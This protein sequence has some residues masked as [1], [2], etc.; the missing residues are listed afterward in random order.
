M[1]KVETA[2]E[3]EITNGDAMTYNLGKNLAIATRSLK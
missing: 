3:K 2:K 1:L